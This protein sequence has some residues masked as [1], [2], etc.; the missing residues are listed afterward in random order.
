MCGV[1]QAMPVGQT[2]I[3]HFPTPTQQ[4]YGLTPAEVHQTFAANIIANLEADPDLD[5]TLAR[6]APVE[7]ASIMVLVEREQHGS[8]ARVYAV[9]ERR[10]RPETLAHVADMRIFPNTVIAAP[11]LDMTLYEVYLD[12]L[13]AGLST[14]AAL[15]MTATY[16][17]GYLG[18][19]WLFGWNIGS[20]IVYINDQINPGINQAIGDAL[21]AAMTDVNQFTFGGYGDEFVP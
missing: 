8:A 3:T 16:A 10:V 1:A 2:H 4:R 9:I 13:T 17:G 6:I 7:L 19:A 21:G 14:E 11:T 5:A 20:G 18:A 15:G 12:Y